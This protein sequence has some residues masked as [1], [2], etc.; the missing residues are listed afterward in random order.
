MYLAS[1]A[2][3]IPDAI[4][5]CCRERITHRSTRSNFYRRVVMKNEPEPPAIAAGRSGEVLAWQST[6]RL[7]VCCDPDVRPIGLQR[8]PFIPQISHPGLPQLQHVQ[9]DI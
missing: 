1:L 4:N 2:G 7:S 6:C 5:S 3:A 9:C 8:R